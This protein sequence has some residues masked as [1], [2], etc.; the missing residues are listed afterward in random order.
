VHIGDH[1]Q[2][3][4]VD[5]QRVQRGGGGE[6]VQQVGRRLVGQHLDLP[7]GRTGGAP[8]DREVPPVQEAADLFVGERTHLQRLR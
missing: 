2:Q 7:A 1:C 6:A 3:Q 4:R 5:G 8:L